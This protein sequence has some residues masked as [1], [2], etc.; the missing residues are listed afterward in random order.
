MKK[1]CAILVV[2]L[3]ALP[4]VCGALAETGPV[5][6]NGALAAYLDG[7]GGLYLP[8]SED[9]LN[10]AAADAVVSI[11]PYRV[12]FLSKRADGDRDLYAIDL[13]DF[14]ERLLVSGVHAACMDGMETLY[15]VPSADRAQLMR[16]DMETGNSFLA[17]TA[18]EYIDRLQRTAEGLVIELVDAAGAVLH[19]NVTDSFET[20]LSDVPRDLALTDSYEVYLSGTDLYLRDTASLTAEFVDS[21]VQDFAVLG[22]VVY[23]VTG[24]G[25]AQL[26]SY[27]PAATSWQTVLTLDTSMERQVTASGSRLFMID[28]SRQIYAV[29][30]NGKKLRPFARV[31]SDSAY[32]IPA[33]TAVSRIQLQGMEGQ[34][35]V[36]AELEDASSQP[37]FSFIEFTSTSDALEQQLRLLERC[38]VDGETPAWDTLKPAKQYAPL[39]RGS[40]G[41]A[42]SAIQR[43]LYDLGYYDYYIDGI[44]GPR[45][46]YAVRTVQSDL[47]RPVD[48]IADSE[49]Q[50][51]LLEGKVPRYDPFMALTRG[52]RG[53]R[54][55]RMQER[56]RE[57][58][59]LADAA[60]SI[61]GANTQRAVRLFQ[62]ENG[63]SVSEKATRETL[64]RLY[65]DDVSRCTSYID[66]YPGNT[67][68]RVRELNNR[69]REL[70]YLSSNPGSVYTRDTAEAVRAYQRTAG[71]RVTGIA[72][73]D[74]QRRLFSRYAPEAPGY[75]VLRRGDENDR[76]RDLQRRLIKLNYLHEAADGYF[77]RATEKAVELFQ[78][79]VEL[80]PNGVA[81]VRTQERLFRKDAPVYVKPTRIS[82]PVIMLDSYEYFRNGVFYISDSSA[83]SGYITFSWSVEGEVAGFRVRIRDDRGRTFIDDD[84][85]M[86]RTG[87]SLATLEYDRLY[88]LTVTAYP[89]DG[90]ARHRTSASVNFMHIED[91][92]EP[93]EPE[94]AEIG[95]PE[96]TLATVTRV[97][98]GIHYVAP[99]KVKLQWFAEG[100]VN[101]YAIEVLDSDGDTWLSK[102]TAHQSLTFMSNSLAVGEVYTLLVYAIPE[103]GTIDDAT[104]GAEFFAL[105]DV[106]VPTPSPEPENFDELPAYIEEDAPEEEQDGEDE[107]DAVIAEEPEVPEEESV[108]AAESADGQIPE[109]TP[110]QAEEAAA[111]APTPTP[112][113]PEPEEPVVTLAPIVETVVED[114]GEEI[115]EDAAEEETPAVTAPE[116]SFETVLDEAEDIVYLADDTVVLKW[117][118]E[119][120]VAGYYVEI[121]DQDG[122]PLAHASTEKNTLS[123]KRGNFKPGRVYLLTVTAVPVGGDVESGAAT[124]AQLALYTGETEDAEAEAD[125]APE[126]DET[127]EEAP[128]KPA[129]SGK[130]PQAEKP[131]DEEES[132]EE[133]SDAEEAYDG[134]TYDEEP[135]EEKPDEEKPDEEETYD[136][137]TYDEE[138][139]DEESYDEEVYDEA[140]EAEESHEEESR[141]EKSGDPWSEP[142]TGNSDSA[143]IRQ[144]QERLVSWGWLDA[145]GY[146]SGSL[147]GATLQAVRDFQSA[148]NERY[149]GDLSPAESSVSAAT[150]SKLMR[151]E[152]V[153]P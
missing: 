55:Q 117:A 149:N 54:V 30:V 112:A 42:V 130:A 99:G 104:T 114:D 78:K 101:S 38:A 150:L 102:T 44:F 15:Y 46:E 73:A 8:G 6:R 128:Q 91:P 82:D 79:K 90:E 60:D 64:I 115:P 29:D 109:E 66:L 61:F 47:G 28:L 148:Y 33:G 45:T 31:S 1:L 11:D 100:D 65:S 67:G 48:G 52:N 17:Y 93:V 50:R 144:V 10:T 70:F 5:A 19:V 121:A 22:G 35:N 145:D 139:Y 123:I 57:L 34:L 140:P 41:E 124:T 107:E 135:D 146:E 81:T 137:E 24:G 105:E 133:E 118:S 138:T 40:R 49:L 119:G 7:V 87:F 9:A 14:S 131:E 92:E 26:K 3:L 151:G 136:E 63:L 77:G 23:Y 132:Y 36:Y 86:S 85:L 111:Q 68:K 39:A 129:D 120:D 37:D 84:T 95:D 106:S 134:E 110:E 103:N 116:L 20:Y 43:P 2:M 12:L 21:G 153:S 56:L 74:V 94:P 88:T 98:D 76:V 18:T 125:E 53:F 152:R 97:Q 142:L 147:D 58:G 80:T 127:P 62:S 4:V 59:Y 122:N 72:T 13:G 108:D 25:S 83:G 89:E 69:L 113:P 126:T 143:L 75:I 96:I 71:L 141:P 27:D 16:M 51:L 32:D